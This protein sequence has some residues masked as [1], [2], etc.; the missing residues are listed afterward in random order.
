MNKENL[1]MY[2]A[3]FKFAYHRDSGMG[4]TI[5]A[6]F[7]ITMLAGLIFAWKVP[8]YAP[9]GYLLSVV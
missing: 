4:K 3:I 1:A 6:V 7:F 8:D 2:F 9:T 5:H